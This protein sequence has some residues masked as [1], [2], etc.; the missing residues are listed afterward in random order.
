VFG[1]S[2]NVIKLFRAIIHGIKNDEEFLIL[3]VT[4]LLLLSSGTYFY[5]YVEGWSVV[6]AAYFCVMTMSTIGYGDLAPTTVYS[7]IFT[8]AYAILSI[9]VFVSV[10]TKLV[11]VIVSDKK[12]A[13]KRMRQ[14]KHPDDVSA[15]KH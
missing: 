9:G 12:A 5:W 14:K 7:K 10:V 1:F 2:L 8:M 6:D 15:D 4:M 13:I 11:L 3:L